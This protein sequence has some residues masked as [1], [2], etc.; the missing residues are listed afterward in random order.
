MPPAPT[1]I[2]FISIF[3]E[4]SRN[5]GTLEVPPPPPPQADN[6]MR[7][8]QASKQTRRIGNDSISKGL[9][10]MLQVPVPL[11]AITIRV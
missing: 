4:P 5:E 8:R 7:P 10:G 1:V 3:C 6:V 9:C 11:G 2:A